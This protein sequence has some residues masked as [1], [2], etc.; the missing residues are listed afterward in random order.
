MSPLVPP[1]SR[2]GATDE[3]WRVRI[4][5]A[6]GKVRGAG[7]LLCT[8]QV[9][10]CTH[11]INNDTRSVATDATVFVDFV[12][13][14]GTP[15]VPARVV[16]DGWV[17]IYDDE[18]GDIALLDLDEQPPRVR[19]APLRRLVGWGRQVH[20]FGFPDG[21][22]R[23]GIN[24]IPVL[25]GPGGP[26]GEWVQ[27]DSPPDD[28][29]VT[30]G[31][32]G[33]GVVDD[34]TDAVIG[35]VVM[36]YVRER[37]TVAWM[38]P[39]ETI[40]RH[41]PGI[42]RCVA[43]PTAVDNEL[44]SGAS[45]SRT[46]GDFARQ[47][48]SWFSRR[49]GRPV[50]LVI[51]GEPGSSGSLGLRSMIVLADRELRPPTAD[52]SADGAVPPVGSV[53]LAVVASGKTVNALSARIT[54]RFGHSTGMWHEHPVT[55]VV[56][57]VDDAVQPE[58]LLRD[59]LKP[60]ADAGVRLLLGFRRESSP[61]WRLARSLWP[62]RDKPDDD[63]DVL[64]HRLDELTSRIADIADRE[65]AVL[66][67]RYYV[68]A[69]IADVPK[70]PERAIT[71][72]LR[73]SALR[74]SGKDAL[75]GEL[76]DAESA[77]DRAVWRLDEYRHHLDDLLRWRQELRGRLEAYHAMAVDHGLAENVHLDRRYRQA[78]DA[79]WH[80]PS[81]LAVAARLVSDYQTAVR[82]GGEDR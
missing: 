2:D 24:A 69:R 46:D 6:N 44:A 9:L 33:A 68:A 67:R 3:Q 20:A 10:T 82:A 42:V 35:M 81:D 73:L 17:P 55:L 28:R 32:S 63:P 31:F 74:A 80:G 72:R 36:E 39:V 59:L 50:R 54:E 27:L 37:P 13:V 34:Q 4:R 14:P 77:V 29:R 21:A 57:G 43:G 26:G 7:M 30:S 56:E 23:Y 41:L 45:G 58:A 49:A 11:V 48:A 8:G 62:G 53:D 70:M 79:L 25:S 38:I 52:Q 18:S 40:L 66:R 47:V 75:P 61:A 65:D 71:L 15:S 60:L 16:T 5:D 22:E 1:V 19:P 76:D 12:S 64:L 78:H 51:T